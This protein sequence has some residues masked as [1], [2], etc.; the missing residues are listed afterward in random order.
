MQGDA[1][2]STPELP[3][4]QPV[5]IPEL[6][7]LRG[8][9]ILLVI[10]MHYFYDPA[11]GM[12][13]HFAW[14]QD[15][16]AL[17]WSGVDLFFVLSGFLIGGILLDHRDSRSYFK[18]FYL[19]RFF[20][21]IPIYYSWIVLFI[22]FILVA[23]PVL[24]T[25]TNSGILPALNFDIYLHF[26]FLQ[27]LWSVTYVKIAYWWF[28]PTWSL[29]VEE[30]FYLVVPFLVRYLARR[31]LPALLA[32]VI[33]LAP[34]L[35]IL[36][37]ALVLQDGVAWAA[38]RLMPC[39]ADALAIGILAAYFW[40]L[41]AFRRQLVAKSRAF[42][43]VFGALLAA[44]LVIWVR[45]PNP[46]DAFTQSAGYSIL[47]FFYC[48]LLLISIALTGGPIARFMRLRFLRELGRVSYCM[49]LIHTAVGYVCFGL[50][51]HRIIHFTGWRSGCVG[52]LS[53]AVTY[54]VARLSWRFLEQPMLHHGHLYKY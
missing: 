8:V 16:F 34:L 45:Y 54:G 46:N 44:V 37:R 24:R 7:G 32:G 5:R 43:A 13:K 49:Y 27:N 21:I 40:R 15:I 31:R 30:Q 26:F 9:A 25:R 36:V 1:V 51:T 42:Y 53:I 38:Y 14:F 4:T 35:R 23:G 10:L 11:P 39:R 50:L 28:S 52:L 47:A 17:G 2:V 19:R 12:P 29:A 20:R 18:T 48:A 33:V 22:V 6:D 3:E 41:P